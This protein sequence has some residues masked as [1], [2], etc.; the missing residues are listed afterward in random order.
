[1][2]KTSEIILGIDLGTTNSCVAVMEN[3]QP[4]VLE[5][6]NGSRTTPSV[7]AWTSNGIIVGQHAKNQAMANPKNT[8]FASKRLIGQ[9]KASVSK[10]EP[11]LPYK[12][13]N[14][15]DQAYIEITDKGK[16]RVVSPEEVAAQIL[17]S[18]VADAS[19]KLNT[20]VKK[21][22][23]TVPA[24][25]DD[26][27]RQ[28]TKDAAKIAGLEVVRLVNEP[29]A[30]ALAYGLDKK[31]AGVIAVYDLGG[32]T[33]DISILELADGVY[34]VKATN[35]DTV[36]GGEDFDNILVE[37]VLVQFKQDTGIDL[38]KDALAM[39]RVKTE[40]EKAKIEL[41]TLS[42]VTINIPYI[43]AD[44][45][46][47]KHLS[48]KITRAQFEQLTKKLIERTIAPVQ[49]AMTDAG[50][51]ISDIDE[52]ILVGGMTRMPAVQEAVKKFFNK[53]PHRNVNPDEVV[54]LGAAVQA[55]VLQGNVKDVVLLDVTPLSLGIEVEG[56]IS[57]KMI[58]R[59]THIPTQKTQVFSTAVDN[60]PSVTIRVCQGER[61][62]AA[63][64]K[65][66]GQF[67]LSG[68]EAA[69]RGQPQIEVAF[70]IDENGIVQVS[71]KD[72]KT[73]K[74]QNVVIQNKSS[75]SPE[76][77][78]AAIRSAQEHAEEDKKKREL[79][80]K[81]NQAQHLV[82]GAEKGLQDHGDKLSDDEKTALQNAITTVKE[83]IEQRDSDKLGQSMSDLA[84]ASQKL[85]QFINQ[86]EAAAASSPSEQTP[87]Q[88]IIDADEIS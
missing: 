74:S 72:K 7:V 37:Q 55:G 35:G 40:C 15:N 27:Q 48:H 28:A 85:M 33:F 52:V 41:S 59:G 42:E 1:M 36:L 78:E 77:I 32:G 19:K 34:E 6:Q 29:T 69:P 24:Y 30:A 10:Y 45:S 38:T 31:N 26:H 44:A 18:L 66:L 47:P 61:E 9:T 60:Q 11:L 53:E 12:I 70:D 2:S 39:Q 13:V 5:N 4:V 3:G 68:I 50:I 51:K 84:A 71:A 25:F 23:I 65:L 54:A 81:V 64:N 49:Q 46:G 75:L 67:E 58:E 80:E 87:E 16:T 82:F 86:P 14:E 8:I 88:E 22:V 63:D 56:G 79:V 73:G 20:Q 17:I 21:V 62:M 76:E 57:H 43:T 83:H